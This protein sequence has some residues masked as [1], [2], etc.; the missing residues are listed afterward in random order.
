MLTFIDLCLAV[1]ACIAWFTFAPI[2]CGFVVV[3][4]VAEGEINEGCCVTFSHAG[5][6]HAVARGAFGAA[7]SARYGHLSCGDVTQ[8]LDAFLEALAVAV[9]PALAVDAWIG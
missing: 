5:E 6:P 7:V 8:V 1:K 4:I 9:L 3:E 2:A